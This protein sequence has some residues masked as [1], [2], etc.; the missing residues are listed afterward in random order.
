MWISP[1]EPGTQD[2]MQPTAPRI[3]ILIPAYNEQAFI[4]RTIESARHSLAAAGCEHCEII[5][6]DNNST[7]D[8]A[9]VARAAG[10]RVVFEPHNQI[11]RARNAAARA[12]RGER[13]IFLD[14]D[15]LLNPAVLGATLEA[16]ATGAGA[17]GAV[18][19]LD[20]E[21]TGWSAR[22]VLMLWK[23]LSV[24]CRLAAGSYL[25]CLREAWEATGGFD[26]RVYVTE[27]LWF[28]QRLKRWCRANGKS[29]RIITAAAVVTSSRKLAWY[30]PWRLFQQMLVLAR[31]GAVRNR[32]HC[33]LWYQRPHPQTP[34]A[35][36]DQA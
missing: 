15:T 1:R 31:P 6:C 2:N 30:G 26:E 8:T 27:E 23:F 34:P 7:D 13:L 17:G 29:F 36:G 10:A 14:A 35:D 16:F 33:G 32:R 25:Y 11:A 20:G 19:K 4:G 12:A 21:A 18:V 9:A 3:S 5:V 28:S 24:T 22:A